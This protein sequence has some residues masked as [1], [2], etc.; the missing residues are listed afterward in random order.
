MWTQ[1]A[2]LG[3]YVH[4]ANKGSPVEIYGWRVF[5]LVWAGEF[6]SLSLNSFL[7]GK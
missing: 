2:T 1:K 3:G 6:L 5:A 4:L 7:A